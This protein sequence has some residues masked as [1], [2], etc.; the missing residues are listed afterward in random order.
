M[1][2]TCRANYPR[3]CR[4]TVCRQQFLADIHQRCS[5]HSHLVLQ[6]QSALVTDQTIQFDSQF[7]DFT[8]AGKLELDREKLIIIFNLA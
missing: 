6:L 1:L 7:L 2:L 5:N 8:F 3:L 4:S